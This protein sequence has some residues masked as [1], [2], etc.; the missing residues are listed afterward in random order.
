MIKLE[1][2]INTLLEIQ[3]QDIKNNDSVVYIADKYLFIKRND[4]DDGYF[5]EFK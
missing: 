1:E 2:L 4:Q 3:N 5:I